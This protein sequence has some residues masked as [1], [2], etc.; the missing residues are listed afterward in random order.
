MPTAHKK[1]L[2]PKKRMQPNVHGVGQLSDL[3]HGGPMPLA[4][5]LNIDIRLTSEVD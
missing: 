2:Y 3:F 5:V 4:G 1:R